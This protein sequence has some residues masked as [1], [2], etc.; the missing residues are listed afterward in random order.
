MIPPYDERDIVYI[1]KYFAQN[2]ECSTFYTFEHIDRSKLDISKISQKFYN[3]DM[4]RSE[5]ENYLNDL[6]D[7][8][9]TLLKRHVL[10]VA[11]NV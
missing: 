1:L 3:D 9:T 8:A 11:I 2:G 10:T 6:W 4:S 5:E 7:C